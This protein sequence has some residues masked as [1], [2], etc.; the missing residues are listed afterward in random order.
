MKRRLTTDEMNDLIDKAG[1]VTKEAIDFNTFL[2]YFY[3]E[4]CGV[5]K[6]VETID[7]KDF[8]IPS[9]QWGEISIVLNV[10]MLTKEG[11]GMWNPALAWM[12][13]G[14][15]GYEECDE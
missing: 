13:S 12:N 15:G 5:P 8:K 10:S 2:M 4:V 9:D 11:T 3:E 7:P 14:P 1:L 6:E